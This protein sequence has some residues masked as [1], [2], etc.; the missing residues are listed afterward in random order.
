MPVCVVNKGKISPGHKRT[1]RAPAGCIAIC[2]ESLPLQYETA[3]FAGP[4]LELPFHPK[5]KHRRFNYVYR[6]IFALLAPHA[7]DSSSSGH[8]KLLLAPKLCQ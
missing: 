5:L 2:S 4:R 1:K 8:V 3:L 6:N 7:Y